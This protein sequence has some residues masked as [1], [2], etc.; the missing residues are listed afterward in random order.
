MAEN[1]RMY[2][3]TYILVCIYIC[4]C[5]HVYIYTNMYI[6]AICT[7][8]YIYIYIVHIYKDICIWTYG[9][10]HTYKCVYLCIHTHSDICTHP[11]ILT[12][13]H[14]YIYAHTHVLVY[15]C[16]IYMHVPSLCEI[17]VYITH[18]RMRVWFG[19]RVCLCAHD[20]Y[21]LTTP[22]RQIFS[23]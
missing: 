21:P 16:I 3:C 20:H 19:A 18:V 22:L 7:Y 10:V 17:Y 11:H 23:E 4:I 8:V 15:M 9:Y 6:H 5:I 14:R 12:Y 13:T 1:I 2:I